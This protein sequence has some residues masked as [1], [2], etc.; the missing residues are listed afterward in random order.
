[1]SVLL[2]EIRSMIYS[3]LVTVT[4][5]SSRNKTFKQELQ[6]LWFHRCFQRVLSCY[7]I[8]QSL[9]HLLYDVNAT[10]VLEK[11]RL[12]FHKRMM[13][14]LRDIHVRRDR[15]VFTIYNFNEEKCELFFKLLMFFYIFKHG[16]NV[17]GTLNG[18]MFMFESVH[19]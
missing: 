17:D 9:I 6:L 19:F 1:M 16:E 12:Y 13:E 11:M 4:K 10:R 5:C 8:H 7:N 18:Y 15:W 14:K 3:R 2:A